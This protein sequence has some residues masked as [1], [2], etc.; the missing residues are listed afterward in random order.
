ME[1]TG[2]L[3]ID[4]VLYGEVHSTVGTMLMS[5]RKK[6]RYAESIAEMN[7][8]DIMNKLME[9]E[10]LKSQRNV[11]LFYNG[12]FGIKESF[13]LLE[14][15]SKNHPHLVCWQSGRRYAHLHPQ[16]KGKGITRSRS[17]NH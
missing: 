12:N 1:A 16:G 2:I 4:E 10:S 14:T 5:K 17:P 9:I 6:A 13:K 3:Q 8:V 7:I 15:A 11:V